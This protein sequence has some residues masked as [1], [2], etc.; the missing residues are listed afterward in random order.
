MAFKE[1]SVALK[2]GTVKYLVGGEGQPV[3]AL[4][5]GGGVMLTKVHDQLAEKFQVYVPTTPGFDGT[6][7]IDSVQTMA[8]LADLWA[9]FI[10]KVVKAEKVDLIGYSFGGCAATWLAVKHAA[11]V[12]L[13]VLEAPGGLAPPGSPKATDD[14]AARAKLFYKFPEKLPAG[15]KPGDRAAINRPALT[16]YYPGA[17][18]AELAKRLG[19]VTA[20]TL[21]LLGTEDR[22]VPAETG[23]LL[24]NGIKR[25]FLIYVY[26]AAH[27]LEID[28]PERTGTTIIDFFTR[29]EV[30]IVNQSGKVAAVG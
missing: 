6:A 10:D 1:Q 3:L 13:L 20:L 23:H 22:L 4:H 15:T 24:K 27:G 2:G 18:D 11:K 17:F 29:G 9:E 26:G 5:S 25:S 12:D 7:F 8:D 28:Q 21:V 19:E 30:F 16:R 14:P